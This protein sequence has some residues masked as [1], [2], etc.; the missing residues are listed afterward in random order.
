MSELHD[1]DR[2][3]IERLA[4]IEAKLSVNEGDGANKEAKTDWPAL[5]SSFSGFGITAIG[6][7]YVAGFFVVNSYLSQYGA[8]CQVLCKSSGGQR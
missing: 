1:I 7:T 3:L 5:L 2:I 6:I 8:V 4:S